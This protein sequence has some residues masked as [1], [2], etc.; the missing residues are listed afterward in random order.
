MV[1]RIFNK[2]FVSRLHSFQYPIFFNEQQHLTIMTYIDLTR[3]EISS[4][5]INISKPQKHVIIDFYIYHEL[6][7]IETNFL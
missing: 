3:F 2:K 7:N 1:G 5:L 6:N 4:P